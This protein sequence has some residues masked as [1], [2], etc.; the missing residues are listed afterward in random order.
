MPLGSRGPLPRGV[1]ACLEKMMAKSPDERFSTPREIAVALAPFA[2]GANLAAL[3]SDDV[4]YGLR[5]RPDEAAGEPWSWAALR[6]WITGAPES[7]ESILQAVL[8]IRPPS[9]ASDDVN[10]WRSPVPS[11]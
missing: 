1:A 2:R 8:T 11:Q 9:A 10:R 6:R 4:C 3:T 7:A 5:E